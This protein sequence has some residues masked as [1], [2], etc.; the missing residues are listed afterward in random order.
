MHPDVLE[1]IL[2]SGAERLVYVSCNPVSLGR[3]LKT[4]RRNYRV[5]RYRGVDMSPQTP[6]LETVML[7]ERKSDSGDAIHGTIN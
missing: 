1:T 7:L 6:H 2:F 4:L 5:L 3:D